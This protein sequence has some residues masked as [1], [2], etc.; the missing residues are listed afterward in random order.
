[1]SWWL[2]ALRGNLCV[3]GDPDPGH[4]RWRGADIGNILAF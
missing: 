1:M 3:V 2:L 4:L